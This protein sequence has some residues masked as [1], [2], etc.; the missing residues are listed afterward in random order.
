MIAHLIAALKRPLGLHYPGRNLAIFADDVFLVSYPKSGNT[1]ARFLLANLVYPQ[2]NPSWENIDTLIPDPEVV[3]KRRLERMQRPRIIR[4]HDPFD[5]RYKQ[6]VYIVRDPRDVA[7]SQYHHHRKRKLIDDN[8]PFPVFVRRFLAG[9]TNEH[10]SWKQNVASWLVTRSGDP[11]FLLIRYEDMV[12][13]TRHELGKM[14]KFLRLSAD[15]KSVSE[16]VAQSSPDRMRQLEKINSDNCALIKDTR[17]DLPFVR[18]AKSGNWKSEMD[19]GSVAAIEE[20]CGPLMKS[21]GYELVSRDARAVEDFPICVFDG[22][23]G[24]GE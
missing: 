11:G 1:W 3:S 24:V 19:P 16:A 22:P 7:L 18:T 6:V 4:S 21:L 14:A 20:A 15:P 10:G 17:P 12:A 8:Y 13:N 2:Q 5:P 23:V 9:E